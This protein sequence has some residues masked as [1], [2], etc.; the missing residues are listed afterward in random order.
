MSSIYKATISK[1]NN[2]TLPLTVD[3]KKY[4]LI[5][6][7]KTTLP[8]GI[9]IDNDPIIK[10]IIVYNPCGYNYVPKVGDK[11]EVFVDDDDFSF[12]LPLDINTEEMTTTKNP[13]IGNFDTKNILKYTDNEIIIKQEVEEQEQIKVYINTDMINLTSTNISL[14]GNTTINGNT[15]ITGDTNITG[16]INLGGEGGNGVAFIGSEVQ[17]TI[18]SGSS[19]GTY[20]G[21]ITTGSSKVN[22][23][24]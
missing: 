21:T 4:N 10:D 9:V 2:E 6:N 19:A 8:N 22:V 18:T 17:V 13:I 14:N 5:E 20:T 23:V 24:A 3:I 16:N 11:V 15:N 12:C 1:V 7:I